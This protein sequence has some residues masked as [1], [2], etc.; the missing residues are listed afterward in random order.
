MGRVAALLLLASGALMAQTPVGPG[1][2]GGMYCM[3]MQRGQAQVQT[4]CY[5]YPANPTWVLIHN[6][7][8]SLPAGGGSLVVSFNWCHTFSAGSCTGDAI[9]WQFVWD[10]TTLQWEYTADG[11]ALQT[12]IFGPLASAAC[13]QMLC[14]VALNASMP[15][16]LIVQVVAYPDGATGPATVTIPAGARAAQFSI[17]FTGAVALSPFVENWTYENQPQDPFRFM[18][19]AVFDPAVWLE[20]TP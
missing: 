20:G 7:I 10:G 14:T 18:T 2:V 5:Q 16:D 4:W 12:G 11:G 8:D 15:A 1:Q 19:E 13:V 3:A 17:A 6:T 9:T